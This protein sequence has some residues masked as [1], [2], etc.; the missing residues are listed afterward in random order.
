M[1]LSAHP[2][3]CKLTEDCGKLNADNVNEPSV[4]FP[5]TAHADP[6]DARDGDA[7][8]PAAAKAGPV[9]PTDYQITKDCEKTNNAII[10]ELS[11]TPSFPLSRYR[12]C[13]SRRPD[14]PQWRVRHRQRVLR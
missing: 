3:E 6:V 14:G 5:A 12:T 2:T 8:F 1:V 9:N 7:V 13:W 10:H 4:F 11:L